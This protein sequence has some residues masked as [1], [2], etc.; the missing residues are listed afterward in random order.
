M[1]FSLVFIPLKLI[2]HW[3]C[4]PHHTRLQFKSTPSRQLSRVYLIKILSSPNA[5]IINNPCPTPS[6]SSGT[7]E[8]PKPT[9]SAFDIST[10]ELPTRTKLLSYHLV[11][12]PR[13][14]SGSPL[15]YSNLFRIRRLYFVCSIKLYGQRW[16]SR[17]S[18]WRRWREGRRRRS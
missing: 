17:M 7:S 6:S 15:E 4:V 5:M 13:L 1:S 8:P 2:P 10:P 9:N 16:R 3:Y 11:K 12:H 14:Y 18:R